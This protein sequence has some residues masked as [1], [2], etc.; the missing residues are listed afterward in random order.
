[1]NLEIVAL[2]ALRS[3]LAGAS[4]TLSATSPA[5]NWQHTYFYGP[6]IPLVG[7]EVTYSDFVNGAVV[8]TSTWRSQASLPSDIDASRAIRRIEWFVDTGLT[9]LDLSMCWFNRRIQ[10]LQHRSKRMHEYANDRRDS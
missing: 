6:D 1:M 10:P 4:P 8:E 2:L 7:R 9:I 3:D 5:R